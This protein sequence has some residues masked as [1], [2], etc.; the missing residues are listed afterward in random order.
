MM[1][2]NTARR[3]LLGLLLLGVMLALTGCRGTVWSKKEEVR[4]GQQVAA[5]VEKV[6]K[7]D[8]DPAVQQRVQLIG[9]RLV[10]VAGDKD[11]QYSFKVLESKEINAFALP[12]GPIY[13]FRGLIDKVEDDD[14]MLA[15]VLAHEMAHINRRHANKQYTQGLW[16]G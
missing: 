4:I 3:G 14:D 2:R 13:V 15:G 9:Q 11:F 10:A 12:G 6:Y 5:E 7:L 8:P 1:T 16:R